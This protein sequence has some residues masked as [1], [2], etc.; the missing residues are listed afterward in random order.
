MS[1]S[2]SAEILWHDLSRQRQKA[3]TMLWASVSFKFP[4]EDLDAARELE[5]LGYLKENRNAIRGW[6][7]FGLTRKGE[8][9]LASLRERPAH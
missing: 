9:D 2:K 5:A 4:A 8:D 6:W 7:T 3:K 1:L